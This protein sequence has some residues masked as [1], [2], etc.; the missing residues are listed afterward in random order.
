MNF[1]KTQ[2]GSFLGLNTTDFYQVSF[3][4]RQDGS[5]H[6]IQESFPSEMLPQIEEIFTTLPVTPVDWTNSDVSQAEIEA[7]LAQIKLLGDK[8][9]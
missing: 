7:T 4:K 5:F 8:I 1:Y 3:G 6:F 2:V 9:K